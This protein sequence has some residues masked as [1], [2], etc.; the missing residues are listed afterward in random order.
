MGLVL[1]HPLPMKLS[2][3]FDQ[4]GCED[5]SITGDCELL[6]GG[7]VQLER[8]FVLHSTD[9]EWDNT[10]Q[11]SE[12]ILLTGS[13]DIIEAIADGEGPE[14]Y[15]IFLGYA[16][17]EAGQLEQEIADNAW[18]TV[19]AD[20]RVLFETETSMR[21]K[22]AAEYM[23]IDLNLISQTAGHAQ[24][25][26]AITVTR[27]NLPKT[28]LAFDYGLK[29]IGVAVGQTVSFTGGE[30]PAL[31]AQDGVPNWNLIEQLLKEWQPNLVI[32]GHPL[33]MDGTASELSQRAKKFSNRINGRFGV[34]V[35]LVDER[36]S[37]REAKQEAQERGHRGSYGDN[38]IDSIAARIILET[39]LNQAQQED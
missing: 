13:K 1:N 14:K 29:N 7:P 15:L 32:V 36:L 5:K 10:A 34:A 28:V 33:N 26:Q 3:V 12:D 18:L 23:G 22:A 21:W 20:S 9:K 2:E 4:M 24:I 6:A 37:S 11:I 25:Q 19:P 30:L 27:K 38:P 31:K 17:W 8:G 16:G 35:E 39:W